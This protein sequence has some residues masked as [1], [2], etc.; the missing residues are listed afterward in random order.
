MSL[1]KCKKVYSSDNV[2]PAIY[3]EMPLKKLRQLEDVTVC[4]GFVVESEP[5]IDLNNSFVELECVHCGKKVY[6]ETDRYLKVLNALKINTRYR[7][8]SVKKDK[9]YK[10]YG[11]PKGY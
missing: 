2:D 9:R 3:A 11:G 8:R 5:M 1:I 10:V 6:F 4:E 7:T